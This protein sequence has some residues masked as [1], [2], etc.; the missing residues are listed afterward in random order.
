M[1]RVWYGLVVS[2]GC[3]AQVTLAFTHLSHS[4]QGIYLEIVVLANPSH[5]QGYR[6]VFQ[7]LVKIP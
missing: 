1:G 3:L 7:G 4:R 6:S 2:L 5:T